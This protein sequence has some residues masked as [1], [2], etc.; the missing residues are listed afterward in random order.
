MIELNKL[1][2]DLRNILYYE[3]D[4]INLDLYISSLIYETEENSVDELVKWIDCLNS[5]QIFDV[6]K[7]PLSGLAQWNYCK[8]SSTITHHKSGFFTVRGLEI[9]TEYSGVKS[10]TQPILDQPEIGILGFIIKKIA[11]VIHFLVQAKAEPGN[12][13]TYQL[14]PT[15]QATRSN[16]LKIHGGKST[17]F[18]EYFNGDKKVVPIIDRFQSEQGTRFYHKR[19]RNMIVLVPE[20][21]EIEYTENY[22][23]MTLGQILY[24]AKKDNI[25]N[26]DTRSV[27]SNIHFAPLCPTQN[28]SINLDLLKDCLT[29]SKF[30]KKKIGDYALKNVESAHPNSRSYHKFDEILN[31]FTNER[32]KCIVSKKF[33]PLSDMKGWKVCDDSISREDERFFSVHGVGIN[34]SHREVKL[35]DQPI[36]E[37]SNPGIIGLA[38][39]EINNVLHFL[40]Q[41]KM[42]CGL[43]DNMEMAPTVQAI[44]QNY[45]TNEEVK[46]LSFFQ[47]PRNC[48]YQSMQSEEGGRFY[49]EENKNMLIYTDEIPDSVGSNYTWMTLHQLKSFVRFAST[50]NVELRSVLSLIEWV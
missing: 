27:I 19:N 11:N 6:I 42:E 23:W 31:G 37:Q 49:R 39:K 20:T 44:P 47:N 8:D 14:S 33:I 25:V 50:E 22:K 26:M 10:W 48:V 34:A 4:D 16:F 12:I 7:T 18:I 13:N 30:I 41:F 28:K 46:F 3:D 5:N 36:I 21:E 29:K 43:I 45:Q 32:Y 2:R 40:V 9:N 35:W 17:K 15:V 1:R 38:C 24:F